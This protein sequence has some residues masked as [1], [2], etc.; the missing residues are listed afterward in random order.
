M[1]VR[2]IGGYWETVMRHYELV[3]DHLSRTLGYEY[4]G[5]LQEIAAQKGGAG[6][7]TEFFLDLQVWGT[8]DQCFE[9]IVA[10]RRRIGCET[11][12][13]VFGYAGM[14]LAEAERNMRLFARAVMPRL[15]ALDAAGRDD[16]DS[17]RVPA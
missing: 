15:R 16:A 3:G 12:V 4:Y 8:P 2:Y 9:K 6:A 10:I 11:Y 5:K 17:Q 1:A 14:P 7:L 13:G